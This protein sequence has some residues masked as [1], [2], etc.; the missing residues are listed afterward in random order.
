MRGLEF[1]DDDP[2]L[3]VVAHVVDVTDL[4]YANGKKC[5]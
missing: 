3:P 5:R 4:S 2:V 1:L